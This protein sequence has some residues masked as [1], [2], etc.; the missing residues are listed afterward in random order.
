MTTFA[1]HSGNWSSLIAL[2]PTS[3]TTSFCI[4]RFLSSEKFCF[5]YLTGLNE[6][7]T[8]SLWRAT[9]LLTPGMSSG[10]HANTSSYLLINGTRAFR[11][12][13]PNC[14]PILK[15]LS[16]RSSSKTTVSKSSWGPSLL[17]F[18]VLG[19]VVL[20]FGIVSRYFSDPFRRGELHLKVQG[21]H[22][23]AQGGQQGSPYESIIRWSAISTN[24]KD[25]RTVTIQEAF[26]TVT[27]NSA[28][29]TGGAQGVDSPSG[30][31]SSG[32]GCIAST[33]YSSRNGVDPSRDTWGSIVAPFLSSFVHIS[34]MG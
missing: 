30:I 9:S 32:V 13:F 5:F 25:A 22:D 27:S 26:L 11:C 6:G 16:D 14:V 20:A 15:T 34:P 8:C 4:A 17:A 7:C 33:C 24:V 31:L 10:S 28:I 23:R 29:P 19:I 18:K 12:S 2:V 21:G 3:S 1:I